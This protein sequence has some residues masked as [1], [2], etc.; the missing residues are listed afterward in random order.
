M[1]TVDILP[2]IAAIGIAVRAEKIDGRCL[3][4]VAGRGTS[5]RRSMERRI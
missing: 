3:D 5:D 1:Q 2:R 4:S